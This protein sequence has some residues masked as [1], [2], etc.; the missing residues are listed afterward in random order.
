MIQK[1]DRNAKLRAATEV[2]WK[3]TLNKKVN[4]WAVKIRTMIFGQTNFGLKLDLFRTK[5]EEISDLLFHSEDKLNA[6]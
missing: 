1:M 5:S 4:I 3:Q 6:N 2:F